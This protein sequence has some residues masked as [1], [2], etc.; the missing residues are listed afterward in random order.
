MH[1]YRPMGGHRQTSLLARYGDQLGRLVEERIARVAFETAKRDAEEQ[2]RQV[3]AAMAVVQQTNE[4]LRN[5]INQRISV[6]SQ[7]TF[8]ANHD[9]LTGLPNRSL[10]LQRL[11]EAMHRARRNGTLLA[12]FCLD[13][14]HFKDVNDTLGHAAGD[15]LLKATA[16]ALQGC[17][18]NHE[19]I[20][21]MGGD[22]FALLQE[23]FDDPNGARMLAER[24]AACL[25]NKLPVADKKIFIGVSIG[26][27]LFPIDA[28][29]PEQLL[30]NADMAMYRAKRDGRN[31]YHFFDAGI[32]TEAHRRAT[33]EQ[34]LRGAI[35]ADEMRLVFQPQVETA[36]C[37]FTGAESLMR[38]NSREFGAIS[39]EEF[40]PIAERC[41]MINALGSWAIE[42][43]VKHLLEWDAAG[44]PPLILAI[45]VSPV[46]FST[47]DVHGQIQ[48]VLRQSGLAASRLEL[49]ITET[50]IMR[51][52]RDGADV[53][54]RLH[55]VGV[56]IAIDDF[57]TGYSSLSRLRRL[58]VDRVKI[59]RSFIIDVPHS[60]S[61]VIMA[62]TI[63][64]MAANL[65]LDVVAE[66]VETEDQAAF[67][68]MVGCQFAQGFLYSHPA[69]SDEFQRIVSSGHPLGRHRRDHA[70][71]AIEHFA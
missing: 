7:L 58:P 17:L 47:G 66:G 43:S 56:K 51:D 65:G 14:D 60:D 8:L 26:V 1:H 55:A 37:A 28:T 50:G 59:D 20:A 52:M 61:A 27:T 24:I 49:E 29:A 30:A 32:N 5:E 22:E 45:N 67:V 31:R 15:E 11:H 42:Q 39:P 57:G 19:V 6:E 38:W 40:I 44:V 41:G 34:A 62:K 68:R 69:R 3:R 10:F 48:D 21:R 63:V 18:R 70:S 9:V 4:A 54:R 16:A 46:Q 13:L 23:G 64:S 12:L 25:A 33:L 71:R 36:T 35:A 53:L 2:A